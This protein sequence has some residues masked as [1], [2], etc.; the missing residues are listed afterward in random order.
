MFVIIA[1]QKLFEVVKKFEMKKA[2][3]FTKSKVSDF[4]GALAKAVGQ[5]RKYIQEIKVLE[6]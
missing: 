4:V 6:K 1:W 3:Q 5:K 2:K